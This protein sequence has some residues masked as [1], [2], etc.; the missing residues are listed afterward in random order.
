MTTPIDNPDLIKN[1]ASYSARLAGIIGF[2]SLCRKPIYALNSDMS[3]N[4][5]AI[6]KCLYEADGPI[7][8]YGFTFI[9]WLHFLENNLPKNIKNKLS[10]SVMLHGGGWKKLADKKVD[11][12]KFRK[13]QQFWQNCCNFKKPSNRERF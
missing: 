7:L 12:E 10:K 5:E 8:V 6:E 11:K 1:P 3:L 4:I 2:S 9:I 13:T